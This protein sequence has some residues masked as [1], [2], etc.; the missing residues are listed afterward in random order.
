MQHSQQN[1]TNKKN[2]YQTTKP[3]WSKYMHIC[4]NLSHDR[5]TYR[6]DITASTPR[7]K[8]LLGIQ[9]NQ[10]Q[11]VVKSQATIVNDPYIRNEWNR[12]AS[13]SVCIAPGS[14]WPL[15]RSCIQSSKLAISVKWRFPKMGVPQ[16]CW[17]IVENPI[18][19]DDLGVPPF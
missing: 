5:L 4:I 2:S 11:M 7:H 10:K 17:F 19:M 1:S 12:G 16:N 3:N 8:K 14:H 15:P 6:Q 9:N 18:R 13:S